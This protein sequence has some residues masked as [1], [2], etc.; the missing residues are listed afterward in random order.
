[1]QLNL[2]LSSLT[3]T[4]TSSRSSVSDKQPRIACYEQSAHS[5][6]V[7]RSGD[8]DQKHGRGNHFHIDIRSE[9][10]LSLKHH[11]SGLLCLNWPELVS[12]HRY[13]QC[14]DLAR[15]GVDL[16][17]AFSF[18][19]L[20]TCTRSWHFD[21]SIHELVSS[22][23]GFIIHRETMRWQIAIVIKVFIRSEN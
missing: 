23:Q 7:R 6:K 5:I 17:Q 21:A 4:T 10:Y 9:F 12:R 20:S 22:D 11:L 2:A 18:F 1:V 13:G 3:A 14:P 16:P 15:Y 19:K 8:S